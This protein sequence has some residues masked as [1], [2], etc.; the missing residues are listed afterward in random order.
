MTDITKIVDVQVTRDDFN[1]SE[2]GFGVILGLAPHPYWTDLTRSYSNINEVGED[3]P[4]DSKVFLWAEKVFSQNP[5]IPLLKVGRRQVDSVDIEVTTAIDDTA[6]F[7]TINGIEFIVDSGGPG[8]TPASIAGKL[9]TAI[10]LGSEPVTAIDNTDGTYTLD[11]DVAGTAFSVAVDS[12]QTI[13]QAFVPV[14]DIVTD[15]LAIQD[16]DNDWYMIDEFDYTEQEALAAYIETQEKLYAVFSA[17]PNVINQNKATDTTSIAALLHA[18]DYDRSFVIYTGQSAPAEPTDPNSKYIEGAWAGKMLPTDPGS[19]TWANKELAGIPADNLTGNQYENAL[20]KKCNVYTLFGGRGMTRN[21]TVASGE[22][23]DIIRGIDWFTERL[24][25]RLIDLLG[26]SP[27]VPYTDHG[28]LLVE[29]QVR[30]QIQDGIRVGL[31]DDDQSTYYVTAPRA[32][33]V[34]V[35]DR[36]DRILRDVEFQWRAAGAIHTL[37]VK[38]RVT[39]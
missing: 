11:A 13:D 37:I 32:L 23:I 12:N 15:V 31:I 30:A 2:V 7:C 17:D 6:Y 21:G 38:G 34:P 36:L 4:S 16:V 28:I 26:Q 35:Q 25:E 20:A 39:F 5:R 27:K 10:N 14:N 29:N 19:A 22:Y 1:I 24:R 33:D 18:A 9:V 8:A 3:F